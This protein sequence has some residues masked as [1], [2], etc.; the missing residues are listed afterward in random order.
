MCFSRTP[1]G[2]AEKWRFHQVPTIWVEGPT[3]IFFYEPIT[4]QIPCRMEAFHGSENANALIQALVDHDYPYLVI[5]DGD[6][7]ILKRT[8]VPHRC[9][10]ILARYSF[11]N[12]LWEH[13]PVNRA[14]LRHARC[15]ENKDLV[16]GEMER[17]EKHLRDE[18]LHAVAL[19]IAARRSPTPPRVLPDAIEQLELTRSGPDI[20]P[21]K[22]SSLVAL[23]EPQLDPVKIM[24]AEAELTSFLEKRCITHILNGHLIL[25]ILRRL[26]IR[27][28]KNESG[29]PS[30]LSND[31]LTQLLAD[32]VWRRCQSDD[33]KRLKRAVR[34]KTRKL[35]AKYPVNALSSS[36]IL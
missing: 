29:T 25:A 4:E 16:G 10:I 21:A 7:R 2:L 32:I 15:G 31:A 14:C 23:I 6:Y 18:L 24:D 28:A 36:S 1:G 9:V 34:A 26:F 5:L 17:V 12:Y 8:K 3:D 27:S 35:L 11:E 22:I 19:D 13:E 20:D 33:H 30:S